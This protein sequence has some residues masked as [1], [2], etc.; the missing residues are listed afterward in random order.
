M[1]NKMK[2]KTPRKMSTPRSTRKKPDRSLESTEKVK[3]PHMLKQLGLTFNF[4]EMKSTIEEKTVVT[5]SRARLNFLNKT[6]LNL[7]EIKKETV[8]EINPPI[9]SETKDATDNC[10]EPSELDTVTNKNESP[11][12]RRSGRVKIDKSSKPIYK[13]ESVQDCFGNSIMVS[14]VIGT[15]SGQDPFYNFIQE[16]I[17]KKDKIE[18]KKRD[19][20]R[21][22]KRKANKTM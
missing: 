22:A 3:I 6:D 7:S 1:K 11:N 9:T 15:K 12:L 16:M 5:R 14:K 18:K 19:V 17:L 13:Y 4:E 2:R 8:N 10:S 21:I 20:R